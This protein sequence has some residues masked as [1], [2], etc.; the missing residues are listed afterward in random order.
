V[1]SPDDA[2][3]PD[4]PRSAVRATPVDYV[5]PHQA[6]STAIHEV[7]VRTP[8]ESP[9]L[10]PDDLAVEVQFA[11]TLPFPL[12]THARAPGEVDNQD[13][14]LWAAIRHFEQR[15]NWH[16]MIACEQEAKGQTRSALIYG[17]RAREAQAHAFESRKLLIR[18]L[19]VV[20]AGG[21]L[22]N[23]LAGDQTVG[24]VGAIGDAP[25]PQALI[26]TW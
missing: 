20:V 10:V 6:I 9:P 4:M 15:A 19:P 11:E 8:P 26:I 2:Q 5:I 18:A 14:A 23:S 13:A 17:D 7:L 12:C 21:S 25:R 16:S 24:P 22:R 3:F 1:Q